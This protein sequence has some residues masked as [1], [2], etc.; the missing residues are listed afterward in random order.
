MRSKS[1]S[2]EKIQNTSK[3]KLTLPYY[4]FV[5]KPGPDIL[6]GHE[7]ARSSIKAYDENENSFY[8]RKLSF[9]LQRPENA[10]NE[11]K[12]GHLI[13]NNNSLMGFKIYRESILD[14]LL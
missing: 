3:Q 7:T 4:L 1:P 12:K 2:F 9:V 13:R 14:P 11:G 10:N 8:Y 6:R 5:V